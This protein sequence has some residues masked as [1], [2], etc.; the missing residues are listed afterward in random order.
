NSIS[1][2]KKFEYDVWYVKN[3]SLLLDLRII[4]LTV[5]KVFKAEG[6]QGQGVM[7]MERFTGNN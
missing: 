2:K 6:V 7:T 1:W 5:Y 4:F 3:Q